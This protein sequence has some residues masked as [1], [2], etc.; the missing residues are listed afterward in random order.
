MGYGI[1]IGILKGTTSQTSRFLS[2]RF[3]LDL[4]IGFVLFGLF[5]I[6]TNE[7]VRR[8]KLR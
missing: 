6:F 1:L 7:F 3:S 2:H 4:T 8:L 5:V